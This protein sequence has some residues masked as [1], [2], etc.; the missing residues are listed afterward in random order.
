MTPHKAWTLREQQA[1]K[2]FKTVFQSLLGENLISLRLFG[3]RAR[4][5]GTDE[6]D[7]DVLVVLREKNRSICRRIVAEALEIDLAYETNLTPTILSTEEY[8]QNREYQPPFYRNVERE[9]VPL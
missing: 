1:L 9:S 3:S 4:R 2:H 6:S 5:E 7:L 8:Q